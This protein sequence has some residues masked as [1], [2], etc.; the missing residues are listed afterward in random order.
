M[1]VTLCTDIVIS[2][3]VLCVHKRMSTS[4]VTF[5]FFTFGFNVN[6]KFH[7][8]YNWITCIHVYI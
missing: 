7:K 4:K 3:S 2:A 6:S 5:V 8:T 1:K